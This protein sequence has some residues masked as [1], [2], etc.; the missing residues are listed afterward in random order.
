MSNFIKKK[1]IIY[2]E[3]KTMEINRETAMKLWEKSYGKATEAND[4]AGRKMN[5][6][7]YD[8]RGSKYG[9]NLDHILP[10]SRGGK[11]TESNLICC[12]ILTN[13]EKA[14]KFP[15]FTAN[16]KQFE[17]V[18]V[19]NHYEIKE[20]KSG[21]TK[22][23][24]STD[25]SE[26]KAQDKGVNFYDSAA[27]IRLYKNLEKLYFGTVTIEIKGLK[28]ASIVSF[29]EKI[30]DGDIV[31]ATAG[32]YYFSYE[33]TV[34]VEGVKLATVNDTQELLDKCLTLNSYLKWYFVPR[35]YVK[36]YSIF[37]E[38]HDQSDELKCIKSPNRYSY[39][40][41]DLVINEPIRFNTTAKKDKANYLGQ[42][43][44]GYKVY[45]Y[46]Y[47]WKQLKTNLEK[48]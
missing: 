34:K 38:A 8:Q 2:M 29:I 20:K 19:E 31:T 9:W 10:K 5:K 48:N 28:D 16:G 17:I 37:C 13:D 27:G 46:N 7:A 39:N 18:K 47:W 36:S 22:N 14:D 12:H 11:D 35:S 15:C 45:E 25:S 3:D 33:L 32:D 44:L 24:T 30:F 42:D 40:N 6:A 43:S 4:F 23:T 26:S 1:E 41:R 21:D